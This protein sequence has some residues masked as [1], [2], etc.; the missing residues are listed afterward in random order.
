MAFVALLTSSPLTKTGI[1]GG[2]DLSSDSQISVIGSME[3]EIC[4]KMLGN[5]SEHEP[6]RKISCN[7]TWLLNSMITIARLDL[8]FSKSFELEANPE[9]DQS[10]QPKISEILITSHAR[11]VAKH[12]ARGNARVGMLLADISHPPVRP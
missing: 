10:L 4:T 8:T 7:Y 12:D 1:T 2:K 5:L 11:A 3:P 9:E 6:L